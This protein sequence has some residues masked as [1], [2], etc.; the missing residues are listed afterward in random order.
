MI[1][2]LDVVTYRF[3]TATTWTT[4]TTGTPIAITT[5]TGTSAASRVTSSTPNIPISTALAAVTRASAMAITS[6][7]CTTA[8]A[9]RRTKTTGTNT[10]GPLTA[11]GLRILPPLE[12]RCPYRRGGAGLRTAHTQIYGAFTELRQ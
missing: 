7:M 11:L 4:C 2:G 8:T 9:M 1:T 12:P 10:D 3:S 5:G 6:T